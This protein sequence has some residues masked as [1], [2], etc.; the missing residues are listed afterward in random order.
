MNKVLLSSNKM[1]WRTPDDFFRELDREFHFDLDAAA[2][3]ENAKCA[4]YFTP[5]T[6]GLKADWGGHTVF[7][8]PPYGRQVGKWVKKGYEESRK[9][10]TTV[11]MLIP[12]RTD[13]SYYHEYIFNG[14][15]DEIRFLRGRLRFEDENGNPKDTAPFPSAL[16]I[17]RSKD[18][19]GG[20]DARMR[21]L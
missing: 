13:T 16:I 7:C 21:F 11:V 17:W 14:K 6:D 3:D 12:A 15:A 18:Q 20:N 8:N 4:N 9:P 5:E 1:D 2:N 10:E 19:R